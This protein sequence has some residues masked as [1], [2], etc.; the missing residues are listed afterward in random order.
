MFGERVTMLSPCSAEIGTTLRSGAS[1]FI[2]KQA[3][4]SAIRS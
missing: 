1:S 4:S 2:A 3:N